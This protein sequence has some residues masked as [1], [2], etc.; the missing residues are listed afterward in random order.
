MGFITSLALISLYPLLLMC[1]LKLPPEKQLFLDKKVS[2]PMQKKLHYSQ[3]KNSV[4]DRKKI[5][6]RA[7]TYLILYKCVQLSFHQ[8]RI[9]PYLLSC[10]TEVFSL[11][12]TF[13]YIALAI[14]LGSY[15]VNYLI[16]PFFMLSLFP[17]ILRSQYVNYCKSLW[18]H[19]NTILPLLFTPKYLMGLINYTISNMS[20]WAAISLMQCGVSSA[21]PDIL[22]KFHSSRE[23]VECYIISKAIIIYIY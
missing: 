6:H 13:D 16:V 4:I 14:K 15:L 18:K 23:L 2:A 3:I 5:Q 10:F 20:Q 7:I 8:T 19:L 11:F 12:N 1:P 9:C 21:I 22:K 17:L